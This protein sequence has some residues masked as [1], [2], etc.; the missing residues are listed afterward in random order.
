M[1]AFRS[2]PKAASTFIKEGDLPPDAKID[3]IQDAAYSNVCLEIL[4]LD[5]ALSKE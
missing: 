5:E 3:P 4:N 1:A 2:D